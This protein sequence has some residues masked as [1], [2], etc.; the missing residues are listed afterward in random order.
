MPFD[1]NQKIQ[2]SKFA[3]IVVHAVGHA[4]HGVRWILHEYTVFDKS[5]NFLL[6]KYLSRQFNIINGLGRE[7]AN[8]INIILNKNL[9]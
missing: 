3:A 4:I 8:W 7:M 1:G 2:R 9:K 5:T 6:R